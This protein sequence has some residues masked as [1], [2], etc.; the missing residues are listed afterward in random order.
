M[1]KLLLSCVIA[2]GFMNTHG[3]ITLDTTFSCFLG[4]D[5]KPVQI[6]V[7]ETKWFFA[8][9]L[10]NT[11][12]LYNMDFSPFLTNIALPEPF[13]M[14]SAN[15]M[16]VLYISRTLFDCDSSNIEYA[17]YSPDGIG[18]PFKVLRTDGT[19][20]FQL[21]S[22]NGPYAYGANLGGT[23]LIR[24]I[25]NTSDG[26]KLILQKSTSLQKFI[27]SLCGS[28]PTG[29]FDFRDQTISYI[30]A[31]P[32]PA[33]QTVNFKITV[34]DNMGVY[35]LIIRDGNG[36]GVNHIK[37]YGANSEISIDVSNYSAGAYFYAL[38][39]ENR[40]YKSDKFIILK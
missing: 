33:S 18:K 22:A 30:K 28:L 20:L 34:P 36:K 2:L 14:T 9:T 13:A 19:V 31:F 16:Q 25:I 8:D 40:L 10:H 39:T 24:P 27:Y 38:A 29:V 17:Y 5:F 35:E 15:A 26:A 11:F 4:Y 7:N 32:N 1:K 21:D 23:D 37:G 6:S 12:S 3:Q